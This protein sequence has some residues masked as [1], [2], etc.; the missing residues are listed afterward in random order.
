MTPWLP[1]QLIKSLRIPFSRKL[2]LMMHGLLH[3]GLVRFAL[4]PCELSGFKSQT[5]QNLSFFPISSN[6]HGIEITE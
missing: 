5:N 6:P 4:N 1:A 3:L 2:W